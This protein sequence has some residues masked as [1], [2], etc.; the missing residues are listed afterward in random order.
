M[1]HPVW[2]Y[3]RVVYQMG[4]IDEEPGNPAVLVHIDNGGSLC[5]EQ[6]GN[7]IVLNH[8]TVKDLFTACQETVAEYEKAQRE[9][10]G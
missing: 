8:S 3:G 4:D 1:I 7:S 5:I 2:H 10:E 9:N 6:E